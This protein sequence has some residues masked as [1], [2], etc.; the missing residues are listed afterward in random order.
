[1]AGIGAHDP[2]DDE[3]LGKTE[4]LTRREAQVLG[5]ITR[6]LANSEIAEELELSLNTIKKYVRN[7]YQKAGV[8]TRPQAMAWAIEHGFDPT[9]YD[10]RRGISTVRD[11]GVAHCGP[12]LMAPLVGTTHE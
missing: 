3:Y 5:L 7:A 8:D 12:C 2:P 9:P 11:S 4:L 10:K 6:G 1:M